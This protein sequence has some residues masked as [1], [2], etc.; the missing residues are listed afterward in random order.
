MF[1]DLVF[2]F[3]ENHSFGL[4]RRVV[5]THYLSMFLSSSRSALETLQ[6]EEEEVETYPFTL[7][8]SLFLNHFPLFFSFEF[9]LL[10]S[11]SFSL[12]LS[13]PA[14]PLSFCVLLLTLLLFASFSFSY[15]PILASFKSYH[16][17]L[18]FLYQ[19]D[20]M[21]P[22]ANPSQVYVKPIDIFMKPDEKR[23]I[24]LSLV[25]LKEGMVSRILSLSL[26][27]YICMYIYSS[28]LSI[29]SFLPSLFR[30]LP[31]SLRQVSFALELSDL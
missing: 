17:S 21:T 19:F 10:F 9:L 3:K 14:L 31:H 15:F 16:C 28:S 25:P 27:I 20:A 1:L 7:Y 11:A 5:T 2:H 29:D 6:R 22:L 13:S 24:R 30:L 18:H 4:R 8:L 26:Y 12:L 23:K